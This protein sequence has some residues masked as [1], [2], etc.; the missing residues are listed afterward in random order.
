MKWVI[1]ILLILLAIALYLLWECKNDYRDVEFKYDIPA[2]QTDCPGGSEFRSGGGGVV[3]RSGGGGVVDRQG[4]SVTDYCDPEPCAPGEVEQG[5][6]VIVLDQSGDVVS[7]T[8]V[9]IVP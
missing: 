6:P 7:A 4:N 5:T 9:C 8:R 3:D 1:I 2:S